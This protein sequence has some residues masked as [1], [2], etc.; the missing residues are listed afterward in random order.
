MMIGEVLAKK[1]Y[2]CLLTSPLFHALQ[3]EIINL[4]YLFIYLYIYIIPCTIVGNIVFVV[5]CI[6]TSYRIHIY[7]Y[8]YRGVGTIFCMGG[9]IYFYFILYILLFI[10]N[11]ITNY[12][13]L[14][15][16]TSLVY[17]NPLIYD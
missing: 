7:I 12:I 3:H 9:A 13:L 17:V 6:H 4:M 1:K 11:I 2:I 14:I 8:I 10:T 16:Y 15:S 5:I